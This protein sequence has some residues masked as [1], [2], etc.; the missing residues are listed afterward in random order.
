MALVASKT[1]ATDFTVRRARDGSVMFRGKLS[2]PP[3]RRRFGRSGAGRRFHAVGKDRPLL[4]RCSRR[5]PK[6][7]VRRSARTSI[8]MP[9]TWRCAPITAS[10]AASPSIWGRSFPATNTMPATWRAPTTHRR[11]R[12]GLHASKGGWHDAGDYGR[13]VVNSGITTGTL[14]WTCEIFGPSVQRH[15]SEPAGIGQRNPRHPQ[16]DPLEPGLDALHAGRRR[17]R[18]AQADQRTVLR[19]RHAG[20]GPAGELRHRRRPGAV[21]EL[22]APRAIWRL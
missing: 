8:R 12:P 15:P 19:L 14:L 10:V 17:R 6:L 13:Y 16:R 1:I 18:L 11:G 4:R 21:Q 3:A 22:R 2:A 5:R 20:K 9:G 7:G